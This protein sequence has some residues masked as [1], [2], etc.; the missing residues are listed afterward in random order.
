[1]AKKWGSRRDVGQAFRKDPQL[2][3]FLLNDVIPTGRILGAG[4]YGSVEEVSQ[5]AL[6]KY[7]PSFLIS[8]R[9][10]TA[11]LSVLGKDSMRLS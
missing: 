5:L 7:R 10:P 4:S 9:C 11:T 2:Q 3:Q 6:T 1:M 8:S